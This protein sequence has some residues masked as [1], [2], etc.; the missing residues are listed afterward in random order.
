MQVAPPTERQT[1]WQTVRQYLGKAELALAIALPLW[2]ICLVFLPYTIFRVMLQAA[3]IGLV[4]WVSIRVIRRGLRMFIWRLRNRLIVAYAFVAVVP[5]LLL[6]LAAENGALI[7]SEQV[8]IYLISA[9]FDRHVDDLERTARTILRMEEDGRPDAARRMASVL[10]ERFPNRQL[11]VTRAGKKILPDETTLTHPPSGWKDVSG[12]VV[13][14][15]LLYSWAHRI[16]GDLEVSI[17]NPMTPNFLAGLVPHL[18]KIT[19][20]GG[21]TPG[22][23]PGI[24]MR[25]HE[26]DAAAGKITNEIPPAVNRLDLRI[27][28]GK[29][30]ETAIWE[31][32]GK[33]ADATLGFYSHISAVFRLIFSDKADFDQ[34]SLITWFYALMGAF[35]V[36]QGIALVI[37]VSLTRSIT[38]AVHDLYEGT[39][40]VT[41]GDFA[42]R[43][44]ISGSDQLADLSGS[45]NQMT[46]KVEELL[47]VSKAQERIVAELEIARAVQVQLYPTRVPESR[48][49][50]IESKYI[51]ALSV[52]GDYYD[53]Q[54]AGPGRI[55]VA[56]G[57]VAGKG[58]S[59]ALLMAAVASNLRTQLLF[60]VESAHHTVSTTQLVDQL[61]KYLHTNTP[62]EKYATFFFSLYDEE[63]EVLTYTN[64]GHL[65]PLL[66]RDGKVEKLEVNGMVV[67]LFPW[68]KYTESRIK[69]QAGDMLLLYTDGVT[70][71]ENAYDEM[72]GE[73]RLADV[74]LRN[75]ELSGAEI[76]NKISDAVELWTHCPE[77]RD[78]LTLLLIRRS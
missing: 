6:L 2:L 20:I 4:I 14:D 67:G 72:F 37:G 16:S 12:L 33:S 45:F 17:L 36:I 76:L 57:D 22:D 69:M 1:P 3:V 53:Y 47:I 35:L 55:A 26:P 27:V 46:G 74:V 39:S 40:R 18:G 49:F 5:I 29:P 77:S 41:E 9:E 8:A 61:N 70:E 50:H 24:V 7:L 34:S 65:Q 58:I 23:A 10:E 11:L 48:N 21:V 19:I 54:P 63:T 42:H 15:G 25:L 73:D 68:A 64:A 28:W 52:S 44:P 32:P 38:A 71:P 59:A 30:L 31:K 75:V 78:D 66:I 60:C 43:I 56:I 13:K 62:P 51:P